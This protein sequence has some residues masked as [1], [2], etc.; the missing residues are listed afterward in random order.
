VTLAHDAPDAAEAN[1]AA[2]EQIVTEGTSLVSGQ[3]WSDLVTL[4]G[5]EVTGD[6]QVVVARLRP[7]ESGPP[8]LWYQMVMQRDS[9]VTSC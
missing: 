1:A 8:A 5:V 9:L 2:I 7:V 3:A 6:G 4:D